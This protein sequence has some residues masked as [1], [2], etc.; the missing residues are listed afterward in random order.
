MRVCTFLYRFISYWILRSIGIV[1]I[2]AGSFSGDWRYRAANTTTRLFGIYIYAY[3]NCAAH[4]ELAAFT[5]VCST[6]ICYYVIA[7]NC[8]FGTG[9]VHVINVKNISLGSLKSL[10]W[11]MD[12]FECSRIVESVHLLYL[13]FSANDVA[14][15]RQRVRSPANCH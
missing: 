3:A 10:L 15:S 4:W 12:C 8:A 5:T 7:E 2:S 14:R 1:N 13:L 9:K 11:K 6:V